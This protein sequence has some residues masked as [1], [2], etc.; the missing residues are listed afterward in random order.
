MLKLKYSQ[1]H[2]RE[3]TMFELLNIILTTREKINGAVAK[4]R[5]DTDNGK[6]TIHLT[7]T[8]CENNNDI[9]YLIKVLYHEAMHAII[10]TEVG[11]D[12]SYKFDYIDTF[13]G[14]I[15]YTGSY[16]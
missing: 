1:I 13:L 3:V 4:N 5:F 9:P 10:C 2:I 8:A 7:I 12:A 15:G 14:Q 11:L 6:S 16:T